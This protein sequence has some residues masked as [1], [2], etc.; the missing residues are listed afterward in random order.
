MAYPVEPIPDEDNLFRRVHSTQCNPTTG[1]IFSSA[2]DGDEMSVNWEKY[3]TAAQTANQHSLA[4]VRLNAGYCRSLGQTVIH[5]PLCPP[6]SSED[7]QAHSEVQGRKTKALRGK[8]RDNAEV[9]WRLQQ[10]T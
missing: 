8:L 9:V 4:V 3:S 6:E 7:N 10:P 2:F 5:K 1:E